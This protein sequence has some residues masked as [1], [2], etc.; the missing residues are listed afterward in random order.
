MVWFRGK[1]YFL[2][3][4]GVGLMEKGEELLVV[5]RKIFFSDEFF[6]FFY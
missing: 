5:F 6:F 2:F 4:F 1:C 3:G